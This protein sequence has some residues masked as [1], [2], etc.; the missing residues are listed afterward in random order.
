MSDTTPYVPGPITSETDLIHGSIDVWSPWLRAAIRS[1][2]RPAAPMRDARVFAPLDI[3]AASPSLAGDIA[4]QIQ[5]LTANG[6]P[7]AEQAAID[8]LARWSLAYDGW[9]GAALLIQIAT[10]LGCGGPGVAPAINRLL[11]MA[12]TQPAEARSALAFL[13]MDAASQRFKR[14]EVVQLAE[15]LW[16]LDLLEPHLAADLAI[17]LAGSDAKGLRE[18]PV[19][20]ITVLPNITDEQRQPN[21]VDAIAD[22]LRVT[23]APEQLAIALQPDDSDSDRLADFRN[24]LAATIVVP[25]D[26]PVVSQDTMSEFRD[27]TMDIRRPDVFIEA[28]LIDTD[29]PD[30]GGP[31]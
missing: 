17:I 25:K 11:G 19:E 4:H 8:V 1:F 21:Y 16:Q 27:R 6:N 14:F 23:F 22:R 9:E 2:T 18:L 3:D 26:M 31:P 30:E 24:A 5:L 28:F 15:L 7:A 13:A 29:N 12:E 20:L 10:E